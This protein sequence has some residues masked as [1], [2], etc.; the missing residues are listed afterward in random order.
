MKPENAKRP[1]GRPDNPDE[2]PGIE[3]LDMDLEKTVKKLLKMSPGSIDTTDL[4]AGL[5]CN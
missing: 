2:L 4:E 1:A 3:P 5:R